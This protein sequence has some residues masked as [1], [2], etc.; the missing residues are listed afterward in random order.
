MITINGVRRRDEKKGNVWFVLHQ[1]TI[2]KY[3]RLFTTSILPYFIP[4]V[5]VEKDSKDGYQSDKQVV[6]STIVVT[7]FVCGAFFW[8]IAQDYR[9]IK[10]G[11]IEAG[12]AASRLL[13][14]PLKDW[15]RGEVQ[16]WIK[17]GEFCKADHFTDALRPALANKMKDAKVNG[18]ILY[19]FGEDIGKLVNFVGLSFGDAVFFAKE[20]T[21]LKSE[22]PVIFRAPAEVWKR[23]QRM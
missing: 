1:V 4:L 14:K 3:L 12:I 6:T 7:V 20:V 19:Q 15:D 18:E 17:G 5:V 8:N 13:S 21:V 2:F 23:R 10:K 9:R 22:R 16:L 11:R